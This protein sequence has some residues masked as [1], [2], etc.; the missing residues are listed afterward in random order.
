MKN[1]S[2]YIGILKTLLENKGV[3][4]DLYSFDLP[5]DIAGRCDYKNSLIMLNT[6][7]AYQAL[8]TLA[9]EGGHWVS[10]LDKKSDGI[11][12]S[13]EE[14]EKFAN[15]Y[16][17]KLIQEIGADKLITKEIWDNENE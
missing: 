14:R 16:G 3:K 4:L 7:S 10:Y 5:K 15:E 12:Y 9:H 17:Y 11:K 6:K 8:I 1:Y 13:V 2:Y